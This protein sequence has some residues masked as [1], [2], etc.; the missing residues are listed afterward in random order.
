MPEVEERGVCSS[1]CMLFANYFVQHE[2][3]IA[4]ILFDL[5]YTDGVFVLN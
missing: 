4:V 3:K 1:C 2:E 5:F